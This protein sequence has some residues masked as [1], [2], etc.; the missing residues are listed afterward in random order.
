MT[1]SLKQYFLLDPE[2]TFLNHGSFGACPRPVFEVYQ[3][4]QRR[5][6]RQPVLFLGREIDQLDQQA[7]QALGEY[8]GANADDL[9][10]VP[11]A[12]HGVNILARSL[13]L[14]PGDEILSTDHEYGACDRAWDFMSKKTGMRVIRQTIPLPVASPEA[15]VETFWQGVTPSTKLIYLSHITSPTAQKFPVEAVCA[16]ARQEGI[17]TLIDGAHAPG[18]LDL[19]LEAIGADFY[20]GNCHKWMLAPKGAGFLYARREVQEMIEPLVVGW[21][22]NPEQAPQHATRFVDHFQW[23]GTHDPAAALS[24]PAAIQFMHDHRWHQVRQNCDRLLCDTLSRISGLFD[25]PEAYC[26]PAFRPPQ[27]GVARLPANTEIEQLKLRL[28]EKH[29]IEVPLIEWNGEKFVRISVQGYNDEADLVRLEKA[30]HLE[31]M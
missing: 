30:L 7:R 29:Q 11:N 15:F 6:E 24:V 27:M 21:G 26:S 4:W 8:L 19:K 2:I 18:Q 16:R 10:F 3:E 5:L 12:T 23:T 31:L 13:N 28:Y 1:N 20:T 22:Y 25:L 17:L 9:V 14:R